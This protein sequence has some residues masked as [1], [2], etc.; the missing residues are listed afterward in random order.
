MHHKILQGIN[1]PN[2]VFSDRL[3]KELDN[4]GV[5][6]ASM[7]RIDALAKILKV[8]KFK[9]EALLNGLTNPD[10]TLLKTLS[11]ELEVNSAWLLGK[12]DDKESRH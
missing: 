6:P 3:N 1:M 4:I 10:E 12:T 9:A 11:E 5:P 2:R 7:E 8:P